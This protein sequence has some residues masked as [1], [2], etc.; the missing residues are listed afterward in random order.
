VTTP[1]THPDLSHVMEVPPTFSGPIRFDVGGL[2]WGAP[3]GSRVHAEKRTKR[4]IVFVLSP[5]GD[6]HA[7]GERH[8]KVVE[9]VGGPRFSRRLAQLARA[10]YF[11]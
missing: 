11:R 9:F 10:E 4:T 3:H 2:K 5:Q 1:T 6:V 8:E 7:L